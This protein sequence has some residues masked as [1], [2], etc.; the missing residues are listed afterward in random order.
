M[1]DNNCCMN[2]HYIHIA[3]HCI[4]SIREKG[5]YQIKIEQTRI[6]LVVKYHGISCKVSCIESLI[7]N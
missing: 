1:A 6:K 2:K 4:H 3:G 5:L 7:R